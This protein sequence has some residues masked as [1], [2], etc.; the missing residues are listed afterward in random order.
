MTKRAVA[1]AAALLFS[2]VAPPA[3]ARATFDADA[4]ALRLP[5]DA[6]RTYDFE[7]PSSLVGLEL[8]TWD[9]SGDFL[10]GM[11]RAPITKAEDVAGMFTTGGVDDAVEGARSLRLG[12]D[13]TGLVI[14]DAAAFGELRDARFE[15]T[16]WTR[17]DGTNPQVFVVYDQDPANVWRPDETPFALVRA[18]RTGRETSDGWAEVSTGPL[19]GNVWGVPVRAI[20]LMPS[21][22]ADA[23]DSFLV[24]ALEIRKV[25]G[26][27]TEP[28]SCTQATVDAVCGPEGDCIYGHCV[29]STVT[30]GVLPPPSHRHEIAERWITYGTRIIGDRNAARHGVEL[31]TPQARA[32][33]ESAPSSRQFYGGLN[34]LVNLLRDNHTSFGS[35]SN[36]TSFAPQLVRGGSGP[37]GA[38]FGVVD[39]DIM[40]GGTAYAVF[41]AFDALTGVQL[42]T[43]DVVQAIDGRD[44]KEWV[45]EEWPRFATTMPNDP[46]SDW[47]PSANDLSR[48]VATRAST[49]TLLRCASAAACG[50]ADRLEITIDVAKTLFSALTSPEPVESPPS[51]A[52]TQRFSETVPANGGG[53]R[54]GEDAVRTAVGAGGETRVQFDGFVGQSKWKGAMK[55]VFDP[56]P[57]AVMMDARMGHGGYLDT[58]QTLFDLLR[59]TSE[60]WGVFSAGRGTYD[61][62]DPPWLFDR[63]KS[64]GTAMEDQFV[65]LQGGAAS[66]VFTTT[67][68][69]PGGATKIAWLNTYDVSANDFMPRLLQGRSNFQIFAP[70]PTSGAFGAIMELPGLGTNWSGG[71]MQFQDSRFAATR[72][73]A[74]DARWES[75]HGVEPDV[76]VAEKLSDALLG[77]DTI[78]TTAAAWLASP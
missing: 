49:I 7:S 8:G 5:N 39:K 36:F 48:L 75:G 14:A 12:K 9:G 27:P 40:G 29:S 20:T 19:D 60:P 45:D 25:D 54:G 65:C 71:S 63:L 68:A 58:V 77:V 57:A 62:T 28:R 59:G 76:V 50:P 53:G 6:L 74:A 33:A 73:A 10:P 18:I 70:H 38:C 13:A 30:W 21:S 41:R 47:G 66:N 35:P 42:K 56:H 15:V 46:R 16:L 37:L 52:C 44:P 4:G 51:Y 78:V 2:C 23:S 55:S 26:H 32:L 1:C 24:D 61:L 22:F 31:L 11:T 69:P 3:L 43:G 67:S 72:A 17:A 34:R 64:C